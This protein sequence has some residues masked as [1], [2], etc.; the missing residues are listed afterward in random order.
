MELSVSGQTG[1]AFLVAF[2]KEMATI[3]NIEAFEA[4]YIVIYSDNKVL[5]LTLAIFKEPQFLNIYFSGIAEG[6]GQC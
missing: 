1:S 2:D 6:R 4:A 3:T 5:L